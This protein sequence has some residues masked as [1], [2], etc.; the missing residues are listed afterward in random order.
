MRVL[1]VTVSHRW[2]ETTNEQGAGAL[3]TP[4]YCLPQGAGGT[5]T[6]ART[7]KGEDRTP[8]SYVFAGE[9]VAGQGRQNEV[10]RVVGAP[11]VLPP[12]QSR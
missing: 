9:A 4:G 1:T 12:W 8:A 7:R 6:H 11:A 5:T 3:N 10:E 2:S